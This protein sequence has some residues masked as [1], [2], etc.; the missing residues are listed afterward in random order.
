MCQTNKSKLLEPHWHCLV[1]LRLEA[2]PSLVIG[3]W[4]QSPFGLDF[5][6]LAFGLELDNENTK[7][8][9]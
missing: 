7:T 3:D 1:R 6:T 2:E 4:S 8:D 9:S 5:V